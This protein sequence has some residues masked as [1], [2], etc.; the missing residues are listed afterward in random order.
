MKFF[1]GHV[2]C[3]IINLFSQLVD[4]HAQPNAFSKD[5]LKKINYYPKDFLIDAYLLYAA[6]KMNYKIQRF[7]VNFNKKSRKYGQG[8][9]DS[10]FK[11]LRGG[12]N[13]SLEALKFYLNP[14]FKVFIFDT[15][16]IN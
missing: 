6:K 1:P 7:N 15:D 5:L 10:I 2:T 8:S 3:F 16:S 11:K 14:I 13:I 12:L 4:I 9:S